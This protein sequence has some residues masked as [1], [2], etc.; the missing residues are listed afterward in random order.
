MLVRNK[1]IGHLIY[2][3]ICLRLRFRAD[4]GG[5]DSPYMCDTLQ[6]GAPPP[7][8]G[9][10]HDSRE[11]TGGGNQGGDSLLLGQR[12]C[13]AQD[14]ADQVTRCRVCCS[15]LASRNS[16]NPEVCQGEW[17]DAVCS[18]MASRLGV[19]A[20]D[21]GVDGWKIESDIPQ[22]SIAMARDWML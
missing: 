9:P 12:V 6:C 7:D 17:R 22:E 13:L 8:P 19:F 15:S 5:F 14:G 4:H 10:S 1:Q 2:N 21:S 3:E 11:A 16:Q 20:P 18:R